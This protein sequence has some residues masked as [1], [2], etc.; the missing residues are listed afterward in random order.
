MT[1]TAT[2]LVGM[3]VLLGLPSSVQA[4]YGTTDSN[5]YV[6]LYECYSGGPNCDVA[7]ATIVATACEQ[8]ITTSTTPTTDWTAI[9]ESNTYICIEVGDHT[10][11]G[12]L[13]F[14]TD[15]T[16][17]T[18]KVLRCVTTGG[19][20]CSDPWDVTAANRAQIDAIRSDA[21]YLILNK[22]WAD[23]SLGIVIGHSTSATNNILDRIL[24]EVG[25]LQTKNTSPFMTLQ[26]SVCRNTPKVQQND[27][28]CINSPD[29]D[30]HIVNNEIYDVAGDGIQSSGT[31]ARCVIENNDFYQTT[32]MY[33]DADNTPNVNGD[34]SAGE[35]G[36]DIKRAGQSA[37]AVMQIIQ[38]RFSGFKKTDGGC[39]SSGSSGE[40]IVI[41]ES[42]GGTAAT[43]SLILN[44]II[45]NTGFGIS[46]PNGFPNHHSIV[47]NIF[48]NLNSVAIASKGIDYDNSD[49]IEV[50]LN[51]FSQIESDGFWLDHKGNNQDARCN[52]VIDGQ[53]TFGTPAASDVTD[54]Q[55]YYGTTDDSDTNRI[56]I[57]L[58]TRANS[59]AYSLNDVIRLTSSPPADGTSGDFLYRVTTAGTSDS[60]A[61]T[62]PILLGNTVTDGTVV[63]EAVRGPF[64]F[65]SR[66]RTGE[67]TVIL[68][69]V[70]TGSGAQEADDPTGDRDTW[71]PGAGDTDQIGSRTDIGVDDDTGGW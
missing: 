28:H 35:N 7:M 42:G 10:G 53:D 15:G 11:R 55:V 1:W 50:Y 6:A 57:A 67:I 5:G 30:N 9:T 43:Y 3:L 27:R 16:S 40:A 4:Y 2:L 26:N 44:N 62:Y 70:T 32:A 71:C 48:S 58:F 68:P 23:G 66:L 31:C 12:T 61:P 22:L 13:T 38:N 17:G 65:Q 34:F 47:G 46:F 25:G 45:F 56:D 69:Y 37:S 19:A 33:C 60:S 41:H 36:V 14:S 8:T 59:T 29:A 18:R 54:Y 39:G 51:T 21:D 64:S 24:V 20:V 49:N 52:V 63:L